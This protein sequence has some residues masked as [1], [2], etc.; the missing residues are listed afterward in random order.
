MGHVF[1]TEEQQAAVD[2]LRRFL[3]DKVEPVF[4]KE[5]RDKFV[6]REKM[7]AIMRD[8]TQFGLVSGVISEANGGMGIDWLTMIM[9]FEE[10]AATSA[11][12]SVPVLINSFGAYMIE[13]LAPAHLRERYLPGLVSGESFCSVGISEPDV[14]SNVLEIKTRARRDGDHFIINGEKTWI[15]NG[16][17]SDFLICTCRT[18]DDPRRG[19][20]HFLLDRKEHPYEVREIHKIAWNS[21]S[22]AQIFLSD[23]RVPAANMIGNEGEALKNTLSMFERSRVFVAAQGLCIG[24]RALEEAVRYAKERRQHGKVIAGHQLI[25]AMLAEMA[26][27]VDAARLLVYRAA[28]MIEAG[29]PAEMEAAMAKYFACEM[30]VT[31]ARQAVQ[32]HGG[33]GVTRDFL[34]EKLAREAIVAPIPEGTTQIQQLIIG[35]ALTGVNAF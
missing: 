12:L 21:Q 7:G 24:R 5:Y 32:I 27:N 28:S 19:L 2:G 11:D 25:A 35:R 10:V 29:V 6:P 9:L 31:V 14:G 30:A 13:Q 15:S 3:N 4:N 16:S 33:N 18:G 22:T 20:T 8:L 23:V 17:Y 1:R 34:V 26:T